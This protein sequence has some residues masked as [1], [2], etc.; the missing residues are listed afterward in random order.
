MSHYEPQTVLVAT[1]PIW[2]SGRFWV[3][4]LSIFAAVVS[5]LAAQPLLEEYAP[6]MVIIMGVVNIV[7]THISNKIIT[8]RGEPVSIPAAEQWE[9]QG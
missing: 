6:V 9:A 4:A 1:T 7:L 8:P 5:F 2:Q 3:N